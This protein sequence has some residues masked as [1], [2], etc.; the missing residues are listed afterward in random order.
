VNLQHMVRPES[1]GM[2]AHGHPVATARAA[3]RSC[4]VAK[5]RRLDVTK[6]Q[7]P[8]K[9][10][11]SYM[12]LTVCQAILDNSCEPLRDEILLWPS[13]HTVTNA[14]LLSA[15]FLRTTLDQYI[16]DTKHSANGH[17]T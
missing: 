5:Q 2:L 1:A 16:Q 4:F 3:A 12:S 10:S 13:L 6:Y 15:R 8:R 11:F 14:S 17:R 9:F 7:R